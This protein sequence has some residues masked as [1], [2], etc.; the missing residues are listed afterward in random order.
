MSSQAQPAQ[1][2]S[3][4]LAGLSRPGWLTFAAVIMLSVGCL[5]VLS[6]IYYFADSARVNDLSHGALGDNLFLWGLWDLAI[7]ALAL[8]AGWSLLGGNTFGRIVGYIWAGVVIINGFLMLSWA[9]WY[10]IA[11]L[12]LA[13]FVMYALSATSDWQSSRAT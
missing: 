8:W 7:A 13:V 12:L 3:T 11:S 6:A 5:R 9:P 4:Q 1:A 2:G 10:G